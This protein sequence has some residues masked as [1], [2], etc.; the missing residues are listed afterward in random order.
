LLTLYLEETKN[1]TFDD[2]VNSNLNKK[3]HKNFN[4]KEI[5]VLKI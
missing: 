2:E 5:Q 1:I 4:R 3:S